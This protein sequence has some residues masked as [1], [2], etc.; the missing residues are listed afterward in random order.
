M[1]CGLSWAGVLGA[2]AVYYQA[3]DCAAAPASLKL[4]AWLQWSAGWAVVVGLL[5]LDWGLILLSALVGAGAVSVP[6]ELLAPWDMLLWAVL[7]VAG[8]AVQASMF[9]GGRRRS[10]RPNG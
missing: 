3:A 10:L 7:F 6:L 2:G 4:L 5:V 9:R 1:G 8:V